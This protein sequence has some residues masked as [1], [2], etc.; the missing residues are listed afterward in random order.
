MDLA[1]LILQYVEVHSFCL[2]LSRHRPFFKNNS[3]VKM[4]ST[5]LDAALLRGVKTEVRG[6]NPAL[7]VLCLLHTPHE[8]TWD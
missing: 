2:K 7:V 4:M 1:L 3:S 6:E 5:N 8:I